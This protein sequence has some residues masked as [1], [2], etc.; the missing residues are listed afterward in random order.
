MI[1]VGLPYANAQ[2][3]IRKIK[4]AIA[5]TPDGQYNQGF[6]YYPDSI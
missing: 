6:L 3:K 1:Q 4:N 2:E 5:G